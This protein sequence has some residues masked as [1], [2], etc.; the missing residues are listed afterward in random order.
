[1]NTISISEL[2]IVEWEN[3]RNNYIGGSDAAAVL[4]KSKY[5]TPYLVW[6][7]K[8]QNV[9][10]FQGNLFATFGNLFEPIV[11]QLFRDNMNVEVTEPETLFIHPD[12]PMLSGNVDGIIND[13]GNL[14]L[15]IL[16]IKCTSTN[17]IAPHELPLNIPV[18][19]STQVQHY[20]GITGFQYA[21]LQV[22]FRDS[23]EF[24]EPIYIERDDNLIKQNNLYLCN[25]WKIYVEGKTPP[26]VTNTEDLL[27]RYPDS[28]D[29]QIEATVHIRQRYKLLLSIRERID[30]LKELKESL[31][32]DLKKYCGENSAIT[33]D[34][35]PILTWKASTRKGFDHKRFRADYPKL[36]SLYQTETK[37]RTLRLK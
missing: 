25:W 26:P 1:M 10:F 30:G 7:E 19:W 33:V 17:R 3:L 5:K 9:S 21:Y 11:R 35:K 36:Y 13:D 37:T 2:S 34:N 29:S 14:G 27:I 18:E 23:C 15:G 6:L 12:Y 28:M 32:L 20:L 31:E 22:Y 24:S 4:G 8:T 16:E